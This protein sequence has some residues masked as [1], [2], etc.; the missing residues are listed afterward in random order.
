MLT[1]LAAALRPWTAAGR[2]RIDVEGHGRDAG[3]EGL[4]VARTVGWFTALTPFA[5]PLGPADAGEL[6]QR[7]KEAWR[8]IPDPA[9]YGL[10]RYVAEDGSLDDHPLA[11]LLFNYL[12]RLDRLR[13]EQ[14]LLRPARPLTLSRH[15][16]LPRP[17]PV[18]V[19]AFVHDGRLRVAWTAAPSAFEEADLQRA[20]A[21]FVGALRTLLAR[22]RSADAQ[23]SDFPLAGL[24]AGALDRVAALLRNADGPD[25]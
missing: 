15:P 19:G 11:G 6:L 13:A 21:A 3:G 8:R 5:L 9:G 18:E 2:V 24:D 23:P 4:N 14:A 16:D 10:L 25:G 17:Y 1:A 12:G 20:A 7:V 22:P